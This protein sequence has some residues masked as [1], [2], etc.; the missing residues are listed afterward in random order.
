MVELLP[1]DSRIDLICHDCGAVRGLEGRIRSIEA[2]AI[3]RTFVEVHTHGVEKK[4]AHVQ[5]VPAGDGV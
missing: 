4:K 3:V 5:A 2:A 1:H